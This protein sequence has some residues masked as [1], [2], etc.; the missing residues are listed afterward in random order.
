MSAGLSGL[1]AVQGVWFARP[2]AAPV[3]PDVPPQREGGD[4][5]PVLRP[6]FDHL[7]DL[8]AGATGDALRAVRQLQ[9]G[10]RRTTRQEREKVG[11]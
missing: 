9:T 7:A 11:V 10:V 1:L 3:A 5:G 6:Q 8:R 4:G 2:P